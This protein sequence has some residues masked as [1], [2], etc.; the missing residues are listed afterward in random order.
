MIVNLKTYS[1]LLFLFSVGLAV[2]FFVF[3]DFALYFVVL[4]L[5]C[6]AGFVALIHIAANEMDREIGSIKKQIASEQSQSH[7]QHELTEQEHHI[8]HKVIPIWQRHITSC[9]DISEN[10]IN[11]LSNRFSNLVALMVQTQGESSAINGPQ[12]HHNIEQ[13]RDKLTTIFS[14]LKAYDDV[15][16]QLFTQIG[17]LENFTNDLDQMALA[18]ANIAN[19]TNMLALNAAIEAAR[20][21]EAGRGFAVVAQEVRDLS[22]QSG[23]TG[24]QIAKK[25]NEVKGVMS[26]ILASAS[27]TKDQED[28]TLEE[29]EHHI[30]D[31][32]ENLGAYTQSLHDEA[33]Q[34]L[35]TQQE[36]QQQIE[37]V[38]IELQFQDRVSQIL[39]Q[40]SKS[41]DELSSKVLVQETPLSKK[42]IDQLLAKMK[43]SYTTVEEHQQHDPKARHVS[44]SA[45]SGS[46]S[47]F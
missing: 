19:Q 13:D 1:W 3:P 46:V 8:W 38:L 24:D 2:A 31:V 34:L 35:V 11:E 22:A 26:S 37:Q 17:S 5:I 18:V 9:K 23:T 42:D 47:F 41:M 28:K 32:I 40:I 7:K 30:Q 14:Q 20:A 43:S 27:S 33:A 4:W 21:G 39:S 44:T 12:S 25:I 6:S 10:A 36:I 15:T 16:D 29:S 45:E